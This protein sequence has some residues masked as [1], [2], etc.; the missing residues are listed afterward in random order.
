MNGDTVSLLL[1]SFLTVF[2][3]CLGAGFGYLYR[4]DRDK[5]KMMFMLAFGFASLTFLSKIQP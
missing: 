5:R 2:S 1:W 3:A 4:G